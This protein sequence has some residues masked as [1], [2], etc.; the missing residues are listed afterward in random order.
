MI[1][2]CPSLWQLNGALL[3]V[4]NFGSF[5]AT[6]SGRIA[7]ACVDQTHIDSTSSY[8]GAFV[9]S[10]RS[11]STGE[12]LAIRSAGSSVTSL[13]SLL[14]LSMRAPESVEVPPPLLPKTRSTS[15]GVF[16]TLRRPV[17]ASEARA[18]TSLAH[19]GMMLFQLPAHISVLNTASGNPTR[20]RRS[21]QLQRED[22]RSTKTTF[23]EMVGINVDGLN[24]DKSR[25]RALPNS[26]NYQ[27]SRGNM[28]TPTNTTSPRRDGVI[29]A[30]SVWVSS[31]SFPDEEDDDKKVGQKLI[32]NDTSDDDDS[33]GGER[34]YDRLISPA[35]LHRRKR[36]DECPSPLPSPKA[37]TPVATK[38]PRYL[39][40]SDSR[41]GV[42]A[43]DRDDNNRWNSG[44]LAAFGSNI[45]DVGAIGDRPGHSGGNDV[46]KAPLTTPPIVI[47]EA[48]CP[49]RDSSIRLGRTAIV[50]KGETASRATG[51][52]I[53]KVGAVNFDP[54]TRDNTKRCR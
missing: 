37:W 43:M 8:Q 7:S 18:P 47:V 31:F 21:Q 9:E 53:E 41:E 26:R 40:A 17:Q 51:M 30:A 22:E 39:G 46:V 48:A 52:E 54:E 27:E 20:P 10:S 24:G 50:R 6:F 28:N 25:T 32:D 38:R 12:G 3:Q 14:T 45:I 5:P 15:T 4:V 34:W 49:P 2:P 42:N 44:D 1:N 36:R 33:L 35:I 19:D 23:L 16:P 11:P 13:Q 29:R